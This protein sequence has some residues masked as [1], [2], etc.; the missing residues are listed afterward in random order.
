MPSLYAGSTVRAAIHE[1]IFHDIPANASIKTVPRQNVLIRSHS[2]VQT[3]RALK[4]I[5][6]RNVNLNA[7]GITRRELIAS[8]PK[9]Y[10]QTAEWAETIHHE[11]PNAEGLIWTSNQCDPDDGYLFFGDRVVATDFSLVQSRDGGT[12]KSFLKDVNDE[13]KLR[14]ITI[15]V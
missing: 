2:E 10:A 15:T 13:G 1:T 14:G 12:D 4:L 3:V 7:W 6:L 9:L 11:F 8:S 5:E